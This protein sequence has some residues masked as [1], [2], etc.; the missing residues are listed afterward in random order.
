MTDRSVL[1]SRIRNML[2]LC[3]FPLLAAVIVALTV[4]AVLLVRDNRHDAAMAAAR[5]DAPAAARETVAAMLSYTSATVDRDLTTVAGLTGSFQDDYHNLV[6]KTIVPVA[7]EKGVSTRARVVSAGVTSASTDRVTVLMF[8]DQ[9]TIS[10]AVPAP[11]TS[12]S[13]VTVTVEKHD[14]H[15]L[16]SGMAPL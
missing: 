8:I 1:I 2:R 14:D 12:S 10:T 15:W 6:S 13:R 7:K 16:V 11:T 3:M 9:V 5:R 4:A